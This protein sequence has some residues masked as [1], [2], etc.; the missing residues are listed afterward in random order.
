MTNEDRQALI[1][2][3]KMRVEQLEKYCAR[4]PDEQD[5]KIDLALVRVA[6]EALTAPQPAPV[7]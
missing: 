2:P 5:A 3:C 1:A 7:K 4:N 6:L